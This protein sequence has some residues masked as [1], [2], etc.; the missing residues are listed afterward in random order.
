MKSS[1]TSYFYELPR[2][3]E[4]WIAQIESIWKNI[5]EFK[6]NP[7]QFQHLAII[8]DGSRR[9]AEEERGFP[10]YFGHRAG[11]E[12]IKGIARACRQWNIHALT[13]WLW[14]T[15]N[16]ERESDQVDFIMGL[17][18]KFLPEKELLEE[19][20]HNEVRFTHLGRRDRLPKLVL[21]ALHDLERQTADCSR[22]NVNLAIDYG[23][24][25]EIRRAMG[26]ILDGFMEGTI[27]HQ[28]LK[29]NPQGILGFLDT[30]GQVLPDLVVRTG[31]KE[32]E[33]PHTS[34]FMPLQTIYSGWVFLPDLFPDLTPQGLLKP[35]QE[36]L[37]YERRF[38]R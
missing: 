9:A 6:V 12:T 27:D 24:L 10:P 11:I 1:E 16:W 35:I 29:E 22:Y 37:K 4:E 2:G 25:D 28:L 36:F 5:P 7:Q 20:R 32:D 30:A 17:A 8:C 34:G 23:G 15:E 26:K 3:V 14:S 21:K 19:L 33:I 38:G 13:V 31:V 18:E